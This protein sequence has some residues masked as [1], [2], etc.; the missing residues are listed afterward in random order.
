[1]GKKN[2]NQLNWLE[3]FTMTGVA[4]GIKLTLIN[5]CDV[6][7]TEL[8]KHLKSEGAPIT[9]RDVYQLKGFRHFFFAGMT[10]RF[11]MNYLGMAGSF[12]TLEIQD[13]FKRLAEAGKV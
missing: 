1:M 10:M 8:Q 11:I 9:V 12:G 4:T 2:S 13:Y 5:F 6:T 3:W 7:K